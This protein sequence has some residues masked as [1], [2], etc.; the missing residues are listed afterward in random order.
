MVS[1]LAPWTGKHSQRWQN[2]T[3]HRM[4]KLTHDTPRWTNQN[5]TRTGKFDPWTSHIINKWMKR[6]NLINSNFNT[7]IIQGNVTVMNWH[8]CKLVDTKCRLTNTDFK[9]VI[10]L[11][12]D[13][14]VHGDIIQGYVNVM[15]Y[16]KCKDAKCLIR[17]V[18]W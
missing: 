13:L 11:L 2:W 1:S 12:S 6:R 5:K 4:A 15:N 9:R 7:T 14:T 3:G 17:N 18:D 10:S 16:H 8:R